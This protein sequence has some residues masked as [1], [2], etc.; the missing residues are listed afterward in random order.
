MT[1]TTTKPTESFA[2]LFAESLAKQEMKQG[3]V[4][5]AEVVRVDYN[6]VVVNARPQE[7]ILHSYRRIQGTTAAKST[8]KVGDSFPLLSK[9]SKTD[10]A[11][12]SCPAI[13]PSAWLPG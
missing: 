11:T 13:R 1:N 7:R 4:I 10:M 3:E 9:A 5:P 12:Q 2:D 6:Y 8:V